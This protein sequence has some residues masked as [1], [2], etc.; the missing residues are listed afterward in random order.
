MNRFVRVIVLGTMFGLALPAASH[1]ADAS[2]P[3]IGDWQLNRDKSTFKPGPGPKGQLRSYRIKGDTEK[4]TARGVDSQGRPTLVEYTARYDGK[5]YAITG[6]LGG[7]FISLKRLDPHTTQSTQK[8]DGK[9]VI[10]T[11]RAVS[12]DGRTLT[13]TAKGTTA[14]GEIIDTTMMFDKR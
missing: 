14:E 9:P 10:I 2:D 8:R 7:N 11:T 1:A 6:S 12:T 13:V 4:L 5:D 3:L